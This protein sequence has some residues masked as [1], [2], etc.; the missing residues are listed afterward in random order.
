MDDQYIND[1]WTIKNYI[2]V[3]LDEISYLRFVFSYWTREAIGRHAIGEGGGR[4]DLWTEDPT[5]H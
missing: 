4:I 1:S 5:T 2:E 3:D